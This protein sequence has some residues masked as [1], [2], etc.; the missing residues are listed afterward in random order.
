[1]RKA[2][3]IFAVVFILGL[4]TE[5]FG[6]GPRAAD[7]PDGYNNTKAWFV[8]SLRKS[9]PAYVRACGV[10]TSTGGLSVL[11]EDITKFSARMKR[12]TRDGLP[13]ASISGTVKLG[14]VKQPFQVAAKGKEYGV[15]IDAFLYGKDGRVYEVVSAEIKGGSVVSAKGGSVRFSLVIGKGRPLGGGERVLLVAA[16]DPISSKYPMNTCVLLGGKWVRTR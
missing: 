7:N 8:K 15:Y 5:A 13:A 6:A 1:M 16:G 2:I 4:G 10:E 12:V 9:Y 11:N 3:W 14:P